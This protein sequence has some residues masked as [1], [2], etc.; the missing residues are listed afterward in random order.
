MITFFK[1]FF[2]YV[3][4]GSLPEAP[5]YEQPDPNENRSLTDPVRAARR[6][7]VIVSGLCIAWSTAQFTIT[8]HR[9]EIASVS[10]DFKDAS[11]PI[12]LAVVLMYLAA[13]W[14]I[15]FA[16]MPRHIRRWPLAQLDFK[17]VLTIAKFALLFL[18]AGALDRSLWT[19]LIVVFSI[20]LLAIGSIILSIPLLFVTMP[21]RMKARS[22]AARI[23]AANAASEA[24]F[25]AGLFAVC[26]TVL[27]VV[28]LGIASYY[29]APW[30]EAIWDVPPNPFALSL[31]VFILIGVFISHW[32][33]LP[34]TNLLFAIKPSYYTERNSDGTLAY[35]FVNKN[36]DPL[37]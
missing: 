35:H 11:I 17:M 13:R 15:E 22:K 6:M 33:L 5:E 25:W 30:R 4:P 1:H 20:G 19:V 23:S 21:V 36:K 3:P 29:Y 27:S 34:L 10:L 14:V 28:G 16:M 8:N 18:A 9:I 2:S 31:F 37:M 7:L 24:V 12:V 32:L 26:I